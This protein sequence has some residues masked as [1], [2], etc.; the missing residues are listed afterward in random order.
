MTNI[1]ALVVQVLYWAIILRLVLSWFP[2]LGP[3][4]PLVRIIYNITEP[5]LAP[6]RRI[7]PRTGMFDLT[8]MVA[9][10][11]LIIVQTVLART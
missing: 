9:I 2:N 11:L 8:P 1:I 4:N 6:I 7:V 10:I 5:I 3:N